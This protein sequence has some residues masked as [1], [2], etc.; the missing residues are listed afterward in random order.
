MKISNTS[1]TCKSCLV[2]KFKKFY[3][4]DDQYT[5]KMPKHTCTCIRGIKN[6]VGE[7]TSE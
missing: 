6:N 2:L 7:V 5:S 4:I 1:D 3:R